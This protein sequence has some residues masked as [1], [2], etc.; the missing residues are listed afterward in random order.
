M[1]RQIGTPLQLGDDEEEGHHVAELGTL[2]RSAVQLVPHQ[3]L[4]LRG[5][6]VDILITVDDRLAQGRLAAEKGF[7]G[8]GE[9]LGDQGKQLYDLAFDQ[10]ETGSHGAHCG[11]TIPAPGHLKFGICSRYVHLRDAR[12]QPG[13][14]KLR[15]GRN[16]RPTRSARGTEAGRNG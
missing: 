11:L 10:V 4:D 9:S 12:R 15:E 7:R 13:N 5:E 2:Y 6:I 1:F 3:H 14:G 16:G 8:P